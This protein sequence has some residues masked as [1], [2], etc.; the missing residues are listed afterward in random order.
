MGA[1]LHFQVP[2]PPTVNTYWRHIVLPV[3]KGSRSGGGKGRSRSA[4]IL[5][6]DARKYRHNVIS[7]LALQKVPRKS[8]TGKIRVD[9]EV[10]PPDRRE[11]DLDNLPK[12]I[13][14]ALKHAEVFR[15]DCD[16]DELRITRRHAQ[17]GGS[18]LVSISEIQGAATATAD[19][20]EVSA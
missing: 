9:I 1:P 4:T 5:S 10:F 15:D 12:G 3:G 14:D 18:V 16:I 8:L 19:M 6:E 2:W 13:L 20:L 7:L 11:R 17:K